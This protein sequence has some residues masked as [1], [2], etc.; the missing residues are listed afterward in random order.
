MRKSEYPKKANTLGKR[1]RKRRMDLKLTLLEVAKYAG[2]TEGYLSR[3]EADRQVP[4]IPIVIKIADFLKDDVTLYLRSTFQKILPIKD[5]ER[6]LKALKNFPSSPFSESI[7]ALL[8]NL[9]SQQ[10]IPIKYPKT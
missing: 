6:L 3:I 7:K 5:N 1:I 8:K 4:D 2:I 9:K 10:G